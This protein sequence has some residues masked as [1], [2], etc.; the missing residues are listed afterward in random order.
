VF[1]RLRHRAVVGRHHQQHVVDAGGAGQHVAHQALV[2]R[3][4]HKTQHAAIGRGLVGKAQVDG[5]APGL[6]FF[7]AVGVN[8]GQ[9]FDQRCLSVVDV[10]CCA[11]DHRGNTE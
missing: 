11:N 5:D 8:A 1:A 10:T 9:G 3:H 4:V 7:Q 6:L 2:S